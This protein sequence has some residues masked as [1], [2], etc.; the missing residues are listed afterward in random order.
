MPGGRRIPNY[1]GH[2]TFVRRGTCSRKRRGIF[3]FFLN[4]Y[5]F[6]VR[7]RKKLFFRTDICTLFAG[8]KSFYY[9]MRR[10]QKMFLLCNAPQAKMF[11][12][13]SLFGREETFFLNKYLFVV[14]ARK[15][16]I[17]SNKGIA[18]RVILFIIHSGI[19]DD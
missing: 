8:E 1:Y 13:C 9:V 2:T 6:V 3:F 17:F 12:I 10:W 19:R 14:R 7:A 15:S 18:K 11:F 4:N 16:F 5:L